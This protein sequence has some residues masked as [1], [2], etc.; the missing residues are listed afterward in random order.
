MKYLILVFYFFTNIVCV[1]AQERKI[2]LDS[3]Y[4]LG[5]FDLYVTENYFITLD[6]HVSVCYIFNKE[7]GEFIREINPVDT[8]PGFN[9][10]PIK[11]EVLNNDIFFTNSAPWAFLISKNND[12]VRVFDRSFLPPNGFKFLSDSTLI[13][14]YTK[15]SGSHSLKK[16]NTTGKLLNTFELPDL[17]AKNMLYR[18]ENF[19]LHQFKNK[20]YFINPLDNFIYK[21]SKGGNFLGAVEVDIPSFDKV[22]RD[23]NPHDDP[24]KIIRETIATLNL[25][26]EIL[27]SY[28]LDDSHLLL[29]VK[30]KNNI[31]ALVVFNTLEEKVI[32]V[33]KITHEEIPSYV[34]NNKFYYVSPSKNNYVIHEKVFNY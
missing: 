34:L 21:Y 33:E 12:S 9:W 16:Y 17:N 11:L 1:F 23:I 26:S 13:G 10:K 18:I 22:N 30:H 28:K 14:F 2:E 27:S 15:S 6:R 32:K 7:T 3:D 24:M 19:Y 5:I 4:L 29:V 31:A 20:L 8:Y 25:K